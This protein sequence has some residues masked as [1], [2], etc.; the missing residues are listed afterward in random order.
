MSM[1]TIVNPGN[2]LFKESNPEE[3][4]ELK[5]TAAWL[6]GSEQSL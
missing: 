6:R 5:S 4:L 3:S 2:V 1:Y